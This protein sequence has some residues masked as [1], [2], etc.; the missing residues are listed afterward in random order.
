[1][2][3]SSGMLTIH[4]FG[5]LKIKI[6]SWT[7]STNLATNGRK[8][9]LTSQIRIFLVSQPAMESTSKTNSI[10]VYAKLSDISTL[11]LRPTSQVL[12][13]SSLSISSSCWSISQIRN[14]NLSKIIKLKN[15]YKPILKFLKVTFYLLKTLL[16]NW[17]K[18][19]VLTPKIIWKRRKSKE[20]VL[21]RNL[22][23]ENWSK[24]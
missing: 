12:K 14:R 1:M 22:C 24:S 5:E 10:H 21:N 9:Q 19:Q 15:F 3:I 23:G 20:S 2:W 6:N 8:S 7:S 4:I 13:P 11:E 17:S 18:W 16:S